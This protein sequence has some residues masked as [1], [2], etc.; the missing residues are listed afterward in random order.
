SPRGE[1]VADVGQVLAAPEQFAV[2]DKRGHAKDALFLG[3]ARDAV[4]FARPLAGGVVG[5]PGGIGPGLGEHRG[6]DRLVLDVELALPEALEDAVVIAAK[7][8][9]ALSFGVEHAA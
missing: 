3:G 5:K 8:P 2:D 7:D 1:D 6:D 9:S 4:D